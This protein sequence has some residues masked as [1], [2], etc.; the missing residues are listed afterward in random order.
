MNEFAIEIDRL[1]KTFHSHKQTIAAV[2]PFSMQVRTGEAV[3]VLGVNGA[4]KTTLLRMLSGLCIPDAG[5]A[6]LCGYS[7]VREPQRVHQHLAIVPQENAVAPNLTVREN[8]MLT[9][10]LYT[11]NKKD[12]RQRADAICAELAL[13]ACEKKMAKTLSGGWMRRLSI[14]MALTA[15]PQILFLDEPTVGLDVL[16][17]HILWDIIRARKGS[18]TILLTT[19]YLEEA[20]ALCD[21]IAVMANGSL[22][23]LN[24]AAALQQMTHTETL[25]DAFLT[26]CRQHETETEDTFHA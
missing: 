26:L 6:S 3:A 2:R 11:A 5:D 20:A 12:A 23:A 8:L 22:I 7:I 13:T 15:S 9:A 18:T 1:Q 4:G 21:R 14:A 24:T 16:S 25:E 19:H 10:G 17:R